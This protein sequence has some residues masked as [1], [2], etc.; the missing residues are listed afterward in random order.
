MNNNNRIIDGETEKSGPLDIIEES[1]GRCVADS[2]LNTS[3]RRIA[4]DGE[5]SSYEAE[6]T[7]IAKGRVQDVNNIIITVCCIMMV[8]VHANTI[9][10]CPSD[11]TMS[12]IACRGQCM[13]DTVL[14]MKNHLR[15][16]NASE[17]TATIKFCNLHLLFY[18]YTALYVDTSTFI[19]VN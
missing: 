8:H 14:C 1:R 15:H 12:C 9:M 6:D 7:T 17:S 5:S 13:H 19:I 4:T 16:F 3:Q 11:C 10:H 18:D 2:D